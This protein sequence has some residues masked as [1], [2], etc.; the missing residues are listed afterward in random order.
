MWGKTAA[1]VAL[2]VTVAAVSGCGGNAEA[3]AK[4]PAAAKTVSVT[5]AAEDFQ[6][7]LADFDTTGCES[8][9]PGTC[10]EG[11]Q[12]VIAPARVLRKAMNADKR[13]GPEFYSEAYALI[14]RM[15]KG[16]AVGEDRGGGEMNLTSNRPDV[17]GTAHD[18]AD[19]LDAHPVE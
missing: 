18:L 5:K 16:V 14:D 3:E 8:M 17:F 4:K 2:A 9:E 11:M 13:V 10:W 1:G 19:W 7:V 15:E 6:N 12:T